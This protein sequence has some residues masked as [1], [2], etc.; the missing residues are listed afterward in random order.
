MTAKLSKWDE[1]RARRLSEPAAQAR[2]Q[3]KRDAFI[4][5]RQ[6]LL[7]MEQER[8]RRQLS[9]AELATL[10]G[11]QPAA[12]RRLL[13]AEST[14]PTLRTVIGVAGALGFDVELK[15]RPAGSPGPRT[16]RPPRQRVRP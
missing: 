2:Y 6:V 4:A 10:A 11:L 15:R 8:E 7:A 14:N 12:V 1:I 16:A 13:T 5:V 9:K 3:Q